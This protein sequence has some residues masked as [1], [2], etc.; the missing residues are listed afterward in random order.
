MTQEEIEKKA[1]EAYPRVP[2][3]I[4]DAGDINYDRYVKREGYIKALTEI[5]ELPKIKGWVARDSVENVFNGNGLI[6]HHSQPWRCGGEWS[7][8][9]IA[10]HLPSNLFPEISWED[11]PV[12]VE[13]LIRKI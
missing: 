4:S 13:L 11:N 7:S 10:M 5:E 8:Q 1:Y 3:R 2:D 6:L 12:E 9:T